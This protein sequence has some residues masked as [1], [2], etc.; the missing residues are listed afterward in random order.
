M[1]DFRDLGSQRLC[2]IEYHRSTPSCQ[3]DGECALCTRLQ[4]ADQLVL[5]A[6]IV[7]QRALEGRNQLKIENNHIND[8]F[9]QRLP[10][11]IACRIFTFCLPV[12]PTVMDFTEVDFMTRMKPLQLTLGS[13]CQSWRRIAWANPRFWNYLH[14]C[15]TKRTCPSIASLVSDWLGRSGQLPLVIFVHFRGDFGKSL[16]V[17]ENIIHFVDP[18]VQVLNSYANRLSLFAAD[19]SR[20]F[21]RKIQHNFVQLFLE[22]L[23]LMT[24]ERLLD[25]GGGHVVS[26]G[27]APSPKVL[28]MKGYRLQDIHVDFHNL[29]RFIG[30]NLQ[31]SDCLEVLRR[32][33]QLLNCNFIDVPDSVALYGTVVHPSLKVLELDNFPKALTNAIISHSLESIN[34]TMHCEPFASLLPFMQRTA[35]TI[36]SAVFSD[37]A[38]EDDGVTEVLEYALSLEYLSLV[39]VNMGDRFFR[40]LSKTACFPEGQTNGF[41]PKLKSLA[42][43]TCMPFSWSHL[44]QMIVTRP[45]HPLMQRRPLTNITVD[46]Y[47]DPGESGCESEEGSELELIGFEDLEKILDLIESGVDI[48]VRDEGGQDIIAASQDHYNTEQ[49]SD[50]DF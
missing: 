2:D 19:I 27:I 43:W 23:N 12:L 33:P 28:S 37:A 15:L 49:I 10:V 40:R 31:T 45:L 25:G 50:E 38:P 13:V 18:L 35:Y 4:K 16:D 6:R 20:S 26:L 29:T 44:H 42:F 14:I 48:K 7:L 5:E 11:E 24:N 39:N 22:G 47:G 17:E 8:P 3:L 30:A 21:W 32:S 36:K 41:L 34:F 9:S 1:E 46:I